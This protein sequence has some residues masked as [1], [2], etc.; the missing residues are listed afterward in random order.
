M[1]QRVAVMFLILS[2]TAAI[3]EGCKKSEPD[4]II[5]DNPTF[6]NGPYLLE[7]GSLPEPQL[8]SD[9]PLTIEGVE[10]GRMLFYE[11]KLSADNT[12]SCA[13]CHNQETAF[14]D[15]NTFSIGVQGLP[16]TRNSMAV[17]NMAWNMNEF[18]WDGRA[19]LLRHQSL[20]PIQDVLEMNETLP[21][22]VSKLQ[23]TPVYP[24][25]FKKAFGSE[26]INAGQISKALEQ[27]MNSI[28]SYNSRF[29]DYEAGLVTLTEQEERG[30][31]L[32]F[33]EFNPA[34][35]DA[36]GADCQHCHGG[37]NFENDNYMNN[38]LDTDLEFVDLG[39]ENVTKNP[40]DRAK[41]KVTSLRNIEL[42]PP[43]M[44][45]GRFNTLEEV[46]DHY[47][48][49][50]NS[51]TLDGSFQQQLPAGLQLTQEDKAALVAFLKTLT[52]YQLITDP[53]YSD[54]F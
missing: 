25:Q 41:F 29:D 32:F 30:R 50:K 43:Y 28:V 16:G 12:M 13:S 47:N 24:A 4:D 22:V 53:R 5:E 40:A 9:N 44:H 39:R 27:F 51:S 54:P 42:T 31:F 2:T 3:F 34:F 1:K 6:I 49:V 48:L 20:M 45:D 36:S 11:K 35:P 21:N 23:A 10:L 52:D 26:E 15:I 19:H 38:G 37:A 33:T 7:Y 17:F 46:V 14:A 8:P 18:F